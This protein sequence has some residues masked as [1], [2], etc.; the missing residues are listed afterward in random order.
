MD[1]K[2]VFDV[3][4]V[5]R[6]I[7]VNAKRLTTALKLDDEFTQSEL[8]LLKQTVWKTRELQKKESNMSQDEGILFERLLADLIAEQ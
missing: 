4:N 1:E 8:K 3:I 6:D 2:K 5:Y 7:F